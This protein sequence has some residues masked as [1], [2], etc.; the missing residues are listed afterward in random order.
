MKQKKQLKNI[1]GKFNM[2]N[3]LLG[4]FGIIFLIVGVIIVLINIPFWIVIA[5]FFWFFGVILLT[6]SQ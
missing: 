5:L 6:M 4:I 3:K 1:E 2:K